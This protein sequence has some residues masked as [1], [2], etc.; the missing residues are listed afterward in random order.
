ML[1]FDNLKIVLDGSM[2]KPGMYFY[3]VS[4]DEG[5]IT[6]KMIVE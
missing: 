1:Y 4:S 5:L 2:P 6:R 3:T